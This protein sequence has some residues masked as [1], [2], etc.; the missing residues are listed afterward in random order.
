[1]NN[2]HGSGSSQ[3]RAK[4]AVTHLRDRAGSGSSDEDGVILVDT[5]DGRD[6]GL[7]FVHLF[8]S[9]TSTGL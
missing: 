2:T 9:Y 4:Q 3:T 5:L 6:E 8:G 1:M 7:W